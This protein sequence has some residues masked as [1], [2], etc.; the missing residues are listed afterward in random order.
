MCSQASLCSS[1]VLHS[2]PASLFF[3]PLSCLSFIELKRKLWNISNIQKVTENNIHT[4]AIVC[5]FAI[6]ACYRFFQEIKHYRCS[7]CHLCVLV[8]FIRNNHYS[9]IAC[10][11]ATIYIY[12]YICILLLTIDYIGLHVFT[13]YKYAYSSAA[14]HFH[15]TTDFWD[16]SVSMHATS[17]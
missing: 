9:G 8:S 15:L 12:K 2:C 4:C 10:F 1:P 14:C 5:H 16:L 13:L 11:Y 7:R 3:S 17:D 6:F